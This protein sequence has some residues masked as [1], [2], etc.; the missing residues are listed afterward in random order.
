MIYQ[1]TVKKNLIK[2]GNMAKCKIRVPD[3][4]TSYTPA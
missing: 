1:V 2:R 3:G 4:K